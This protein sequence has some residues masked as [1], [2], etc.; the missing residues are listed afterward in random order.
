MLR[1]VRMC[2]SELLLGD[3]PCSYALPEGV[4]GVLH[5]LTHVSSSRG[6]PVLCVHHSWQTYT[7]YYKY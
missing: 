3:S 7:C 6:M 2:S 5:T 1:L 4:V